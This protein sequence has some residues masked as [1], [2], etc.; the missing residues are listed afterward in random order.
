MGFQNSTFPLAIYGCIDTSSRKILWLKV[1][2]SNSKPEIIGRWFL[3]YLYETRT[4][5]AY[6]R[7]DKGTETVIMSAMQAYL[8]QKHDDLEDP[9]DSVIYGPSTSNQASE[10]IFL[11]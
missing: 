3:E 11:L 2:T 4:L 8:R 6:L 1:W 7:I 10:N 5:P 9:T